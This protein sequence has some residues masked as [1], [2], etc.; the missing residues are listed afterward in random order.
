M[1]YLF[2]QPIFGPS[3]HHLQRNLDSVRSMKN[4]LEKHPED[5]KMLF[6]GWCIN[7]EFWNTISNEISSAFGNKILEIRR[8]DRNYGKAHI[9]NELMSKPE[10]SEYKYI[11]SADSDIVFITPNMFERLHKCAEISE[12]RKKTQFGLISC[13]HLLNDRN[14]P[15]A[16]QRSFEFY[17]PKLNT[18]EKVVWGN[19]PMGI[20]GGCWMFSRKAWDKHKGYRLQGVYAGEDAYFSYNMKPLGLSW[21]IA[22]SI[23]VEHPWD[24]DKEYEDFK[25]RICVRDT[26]GID[27]DTIE[28]QIQEMEEFWNKRT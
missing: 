10:A 1:T 23:P 28:P 15:S 14:W 24:T 13:K 18:K 27:K 25:L 6:G 9:V 2:V 12:I 26:N 4:L 5:V 11:L 3:Q 17:N 7:D 21:Q 16:T 19:L 20:G 22:E 8:F